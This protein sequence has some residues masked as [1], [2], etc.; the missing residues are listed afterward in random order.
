MARTIIDLP[1]EFVFQTEIPLML[2]HMNM[3][4][5]LDNA[6]LLSLVSEARPKYWAAQGYADLSVIDGVKIFVG[7]VSVMYI[8]EAK[9]PSI[10]V[11][12]MAFG[13]FSKYGFDI[14]WQMSDLATGVEVARGKNGMGC[15]NPETRKVALLPEPLKKR[16]AGL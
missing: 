6:L 12:K 4:G 10:M 1:G 15:I 5:H 13:D 9:C 3:G 2:M 11:V 16:L 14:L 8:A 7:D